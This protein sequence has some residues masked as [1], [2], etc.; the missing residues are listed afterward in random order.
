MNKTK[1]DRENLGVELYGVQQEL[2]RQQMMLEKHH[3]DHA[4]VKQ[5]RGLTED[6]LSEVRDMYRQKQTGLTKERKKGQ[7]AAPLSQS[8]KTQKLQGLF[9]EL[10]VLF[11]PLSMC[12]SFADLLYLCGHFC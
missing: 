8:Q 9:A 5:D 2:A 3:D 10:S 4:Q 6:K 12:V 1:R 11:C 7:Y